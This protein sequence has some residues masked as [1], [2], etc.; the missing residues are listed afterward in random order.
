MAIEAVVIGLFL[1]FEFEDVQS[2]SFL[3]INQPSCF[4]PE[5]KNTIIMFGG[6]R[7]HMYLGILRWAYK[8]IPLCKNYLNFDFVEEEFVEFHEW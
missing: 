6:L 1:V 8:M 7:L 3:P 2:V 4:N 5:N